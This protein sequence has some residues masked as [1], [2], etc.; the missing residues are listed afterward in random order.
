MLSK[1]PLVG[2]PEK[3]VE[4]LTELGGLGMSYAIG[5]FVDAAYDRSSIELFA[6]KV[7]P[8]LAG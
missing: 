8:Q 1:G 5:Y 6:S 4:R 3:I 2:T 7:I